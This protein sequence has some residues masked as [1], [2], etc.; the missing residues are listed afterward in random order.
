VSPA[1]FLIFPVVAMTKFGIGYQ[2]FPA[3]ITALFPMI[4]PFWRWFVIIH[5]HKRQ[6]AL[7][8]GDT[9]VKS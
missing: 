1:H 7:S 5:D 9:T 2:Y 6:L 3:C 4:S 8:K